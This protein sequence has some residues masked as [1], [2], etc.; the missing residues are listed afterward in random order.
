MASPT[1]GEV[2][3][4]AVGSRSDVGELG[5]APQLSRQSLQLGEP[6][7]C[8]LLPLCSLLFS[9]SPVLSSLFFFSISFAG[10]LFL[11]V[12]QF[13]CLLLFSIKAFFF[14]PP[15]VFLFFFFL[16]SFSPLLPFS[17]SLLPP[18]LLSFFLSFSLPATHFLIHPILSTPLL[19]FH[20]F[21]TFVALALNSMPGRGALCKDRNP[22]SFHKL[23]PYSHPHVFL[24]SF[25]C[26]GLVSALGIL[27]PP[28]ISSSLLEKSCW[29]LTGAVGGGGEDLK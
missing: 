7:S 24:F 26:W 14:S 20:L 25:P 8:L 21:I 16:S 29:M 12:F 1:R 27:A 9:S 2:G 18:S 5:C 6:L 3:S 10:F 19:Q 15:P 11:P 22:P 28:P 17:F 13:L 23:N 4:G